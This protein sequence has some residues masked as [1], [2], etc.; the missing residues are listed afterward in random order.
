MADWWNLGVPLTDYSSITSSDL[1]DES[2]TVGKIDTDVSKYIPGVATILL[3]SHS[4]ND[5]YIATVQLYDVAGNAWARRQH[6]RVYVQ[7][8]TEDAGAA[9]CSTAPG[10]FGIKSTATT[11]SSGTAFTFAYTLNSGVA[12]ST[13][14]AGS[15]KEFITTSDGVL[16]VSLT[17]A[18][19]EA[20]TY[21]LVLDW[22]G[23]VVKSSDTFGTTVAAT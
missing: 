3:S 8:S 2:V 14:T 7:A 5:E 6:V 4:S 16:T 13:N 20:S 21:V 15:D 9:L 18:A 19:A 1:A 22:L 10:G 17:C 11:D 23:G 12:A